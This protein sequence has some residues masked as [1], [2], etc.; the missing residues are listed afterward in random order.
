MTRYM[1]GHVARIT[2]RNPDRHAAMKSLLALLALMVFVL[3]LEKLWLPSA[4]ADECDGLGPAATL[5]CATFGAP[6]D[7]E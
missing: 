5:T 7:G 1:G 4:Q 2:M 6:P 3:M